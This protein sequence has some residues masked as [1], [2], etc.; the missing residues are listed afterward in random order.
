MFLFTAGAEA[1]FYDD[2]WFEEMQVDEL[3]LHLAFE[4]ESFDL[5]LLPNLYGDIISDLCAGLV[6]G[7]GLAP[8]ANLGWEYAVF[9]AV[10]GS[11]PD[12]AGKGLANPVAM[13][14]SAA[15]ML[16]H[17]SERLAAGAIR[18][19]VTAVLA[20]GEVRTRDLGGSSTTLEVA[21]CT[22]AIWPVISSVALPVW[23]ASD[24]TSPATT[25]KPLPASPARAASMVA[26]NASM[27]VLRAIARFR[28][29]RVN[30][31]GRLSRDWCQFVKN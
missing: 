5:L 13:I 29:V 15:M 10:H 23:L 25:A 9:E 27:L 16:D 4:P 19:A 6:G 18:S 21:L 3:A 26:F 8:G 1:Q 17:L 22:I 30:F 20:A 31:F 7:L 12:I 14:L 11:A 2:V 28:K 24:L